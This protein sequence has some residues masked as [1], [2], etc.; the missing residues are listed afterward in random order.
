MKKDEEP[1]VVEQAF[2]VPAERVWAAITKIEEMRQWYFANIPAFKAEVG[3]ETEFNVNSGGRDFPHLWKVTEV[4]PQE[5]ITYDFKFGGYAGNAYVSFE[6]FAQGEGATLRVTYRVVEDMAEGIPEFERE[7]GVAGWT[8]FIK[9]R[10][11][12]YLEKVE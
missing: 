4:I 1:I 12:A 3:F 8:Y 7:S 9:Q 11:K 5:K 10:L 2:S 6:L